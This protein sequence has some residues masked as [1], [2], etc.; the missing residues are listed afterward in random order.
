MKIQ[1]ALLALSILILTSC[2]G[3]ADVSLKGSCTVAA[4][5]YCEE[6]YGSIW[7]ETT[8]G[9]TDTFSEEACSTTD[10]IGTCT[11]ENG[12][13]SDLNVL[14]YTGYAGGVTDAETDCE[15]TRDLSPDGTNTW[16]AGI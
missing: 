1:K 4:D 3:D 9:C 7:N 13:A 11:L 10:R 8:I 2:G 6:Y 15:V 12:G 5:F 16:A 14:Y